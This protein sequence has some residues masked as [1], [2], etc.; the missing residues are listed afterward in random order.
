[1]DGWGQVYRLDKL[2]W[3]WQ[4]LSP[5]GRSGLRHG[6]SGGVA[7]VRIFRAAATAEGVA[8]LHGEAAL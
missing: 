8:F 7:M 3:W 1:M 5:R 2:L 4:W 6:I